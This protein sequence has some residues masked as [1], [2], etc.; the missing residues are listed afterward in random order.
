[1]INKGAQKAIS[2]LEEIGMDEITDVPM[3]I[4]VSALGATIIKEPMERCDG[5]IIRGNKTTLIKV[6][7]NIPYEERV[8]FT[9]AHEVGHYLLH[10]K[11]EVHNEN[12]NTL[13]WFKDTEKQAQMG[14]QEFEANEFASELLIPRKLIIEEYGNESFSP[15][16]IEKISKRFKTSITSTIFKYCKLNLHPILIAF[17]RNGNIEYFCRSIDF[18]YW[19]KD[20]RKLPPPQDSVAKEYID[21]NYD[22]V[23][24]ES[25]KQ[26]DIIKST[27]LNLGKYDQDSPFFEYCVPTKQYKTLVSVIW[28]R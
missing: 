4:F 6:N 26:Q 19:I 21:A 16:L 13:N 5:K 3:D 24:R 14:I 28:E 9:I 8:R 27:W 11:L 18:K 10:E 22:F 17:I 23:Y 7:S 12:H 15:Q 2:L 25:E 1:M 20:L